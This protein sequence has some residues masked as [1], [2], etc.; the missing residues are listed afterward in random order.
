MPREETGVAVV[1]RDTELP[2]VVLPM[3][4]D[5]PLLE[6]T[7]CNISYS[8]PGFCNKS[9]GRIRFNEGWIKGNYLKVLI[10]ELNIRLVNITDL[11]TFHIK[12]F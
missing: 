10:L 8:C 1:A 11:F 3:S 6:Y 7:L 5:R 2:Q 4:D 12:E 9:K